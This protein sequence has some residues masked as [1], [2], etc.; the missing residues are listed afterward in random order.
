MM[1]I[2]QDQ[3][4]AMWRQCGEWVYVWYIGEMNPTYL[5]IQTTTA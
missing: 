4:D 2:P 3:I 1:L 5:L